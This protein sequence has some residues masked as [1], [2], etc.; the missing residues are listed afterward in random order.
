LGAVSNS[1]HAVTGQREV[2]PDRPEV[3]QE[4]LRAPWI[5]ETC[6]W[7]SRRRV[8]SWLFSARLFARV[9]AFTETCFTPASCGTLAFAAR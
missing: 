2:L 3:R 7:R 6:I 9:E 1:A 8:G 5:A 4:V